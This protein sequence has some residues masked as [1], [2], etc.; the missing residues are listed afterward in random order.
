M[1]TAAKAKR[2]RL[3]ARVSAEQKEII[4]HA[5]TLAGLSLTDFILQAVQHAADETIRDYQV[6]TL[7][8]RDSRV[9]AEAILAPP[10]PNDRL[11]EVARRASARITFVPKLDGE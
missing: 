9:F 6:L 2:E 10:E 3:V 7:S 8:A 4:E 5:A 1:A 11:R